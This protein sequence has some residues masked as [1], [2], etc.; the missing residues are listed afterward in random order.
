MKSGSVTLWRK[1]HR[2]ERIGI[3]PGDGGSDDDDPQVDHEP[4]V[5]QLPDHG[6]GIAYSIHTFLPAEPWTLVIIFCRF[7]EHIARPFPWMDFAVP[8]MG[9]ACQRGRSASRR[10]SPRCRR[11]PRPGYPK[12]GR[13]GI[14]IGPIRLSPRATRASR[15]GSAKENRACDHYAALV[16][17]KL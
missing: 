5:E 16:Q 10:L 12:G 4:G 2:V 13:A 9:P 11:A 7:H 8:S 17:K 1:H 6:K 15:G 14:P 3:H